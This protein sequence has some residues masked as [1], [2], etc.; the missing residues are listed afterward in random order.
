MPVRWVNAAMHLDSVGA[1]LKAQDLL[2]R[3]SI[4]VDLDG[5]KEKMKHT[6]TVDWTAEMILPHI[7][8]RL[9][10]EE[11]YRMHSPPPSFGR[12]TTEI[13]TLRVR[14]LL[15]KT[16]E[17]PNV[18]MGKT[19]FED[20]MLEISRQ[21]GILKDYQRLIWN[22]QDLHKRAVP[23]DYGITPEE[24]L[25]VVYHMRGGSYHITTGPDIYG[26]A[27]VV[28]PSPMGKHEYLVGVPKS[29]CSG[30]V[31]NAVV[32]LSVD[33]MRDLPEKFYIGVQGYPYKPFDIENP[34][35]ILITKDSRPRFFVVAESEEPDAAPV[36]GPEV[37]AC[38]D[39]V[40]WVMCEE[41]QEEWV[42]VEKE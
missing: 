3:P 16:I 35:R 27:S 40:E 41:N 11:V 5:L 8:K 30:A 12:S 24:T 18:H 15:D 6:R 32:S 37:V 33:M 2:R 20:I 9:Y 28:V 39:S 42:L 19:T 31:R 26:S 23:S 10:P 22:G 7:P 38:D 36:L 4:T 14:T 21:E 34:S 1:S 25:H 13:G 29:F 17:I